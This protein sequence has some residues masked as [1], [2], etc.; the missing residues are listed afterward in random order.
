MRFRVII[1][2]DEDGVFVAECPA[3]P[4]CVSEGKTREEAMANIRD[5]IQGYLQS[6]EKHGEPIPGG[7]TEEIV[8]V[9]V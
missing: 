1:E 4:G 2:P 6:L 7:I 5:A 3:L 8:E 9:S